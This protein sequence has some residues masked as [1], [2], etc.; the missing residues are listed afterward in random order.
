MVDGDATDSAEP[1]LHVAQSDDQVLADS[2]LGHGTGHVHV[3]Q[4][5]TGDLDFLAAL[6]DLVRCGH[7]LV[8]D[9]GCELGEGGVGNPSSALGWLVGACEG[10]DGRK[11]GS[12][13]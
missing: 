3:Q 10:G 1:G 5:H 8:E 2:L 4:V 6:K 11:S 7:V 12:D 13:S 9:V